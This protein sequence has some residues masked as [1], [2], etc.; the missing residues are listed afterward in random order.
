[1]AKK[2]RENMP[3]SHTLMIL[4]LNSKVTNQFIEEI[5]AVAEAR[6][7]ITDSIRVEIAHNAREV[8]ERSVSH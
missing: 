1:M 7:N 6:G 4:E 2:L 3:S 8:A 5:K